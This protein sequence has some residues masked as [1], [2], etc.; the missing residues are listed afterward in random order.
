M[1]TVIIC[2]GQLPAR[3]LYDALQSEGVNCHLI[4]GAFDASGLDAKV[5]IRQAAI[6]AAEI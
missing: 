5:A 3:G 2:A 4:G 6:L 1:D